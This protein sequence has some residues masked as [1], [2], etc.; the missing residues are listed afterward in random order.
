MI[1]CNQ[2]K[3]ITSKFPKLIRS[4]NEFGGAYGNFMSFLG[5]FFSFIWK[6]NLN[7]L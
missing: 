6:G 1:L 4:F 3:F 5:L 7:A 2:S